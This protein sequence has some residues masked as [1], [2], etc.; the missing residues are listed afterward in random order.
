MYTHKSA[1]KVKISL[2][3]R[4]LTAPLSHSSMTDASGSHVR[5]QGSEL[6]VCGRRLTC[7]MGSHSMTATQYRRNRPCLYGR[8]ARPPHI[9]AV[10]FAAVKPVPICT[11]W[12]TVA[13]VCEQLA[14][15]RYLAVP[16]SRSRTCN[17]S[18]T[19]SARYRYTTKPHALQLNDQ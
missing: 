10:T 19:G 16:P 4:Q 7:R 13:L 2:N 6:A 12:W 17:L 18:V 8:R 1:K 14:Q 5:F 9:T 15:G 3:R 11:A